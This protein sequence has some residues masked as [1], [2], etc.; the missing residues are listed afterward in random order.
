MNYKIAQLAISPDQK[1][2]TISKIIISQPS[3]EQ[4]NLL[5]R[6]FIMLEFKSR[7]TELIRL[8]NF[9]VEQIKTNYYRNEQI[10][11]LEKTAS[12]KVEHIFESAISKLNQNIIE[13]L[14]AEKIKFSPANLNITIGIICHSQLH[15]ATLGHNKAL[16]IYQPKGSK[17]AS[18]AE[19]PSDK[20][21]DLINITKKTADPTQE[22][23]NLNKLFSNIINGSIPVGGYFVFTNEA[24]YE[25]LSEKQ[26]VDIITTLPPASAVEQIKNVLQ[27]TNVYVP[28]LGLI[29]KNGRETSTSI[30]PKPTIR[31]QQ[32]AG[33]PV[34]PIPAPTPNFLPADTGLGSFE[35][36]NETEEKTAQIL[37]PTGLLNFKKIKSIINRLDLNKW[38]KAQS[39]NTLTFKNQLA[40][41]HKLSF[42]RLF[43]IAK[44]TGQVLLG[45]S[46]GLMKTITDKDKIG[47][48]K[49]NLVAKK[50]RLSKKH[51]IMLGVLAVVILGLVG[52]LIYS[53]IKNKRLAAEQA[54]ADQVELIRQKQSQIETFLI[55]DNLTEARDNLV[56]IDQLLQELPQDTPTRQ[57]TYQELKN[58]FNEKND[59]INH[60]TRLEPRIVADLSP[61]QPD[62]LVLVSNKLYLADNSNKKIY[63]LDPTDGQNAP[64]LD[65]AL[66]KNLSW[67]ALDDNNN[68]YY[69]SS[70]NS[71]VA[72]DPSSQRITNLSSNELSDNISTLTVYGNRV[73]IFATKDKQIY[74]YNRYDDTLANQRGWL[75]SDELSNIQSMSI[76]GYIYL[77]ADKTIYK[78]GGGHKQ[79]F[80]LENIY[81][82][83]TDPQKIIAL[84]NYEIFYVLEPANNRLVVFNKSGRFLAQY[85]SDDFQDL[86][87]FTVDEV[88][89]KAYVL[90]QNK[91]YELPLWSNQ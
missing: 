27:Q 21:Y 49:N 22:I 74:R 73:Y 51:L 62:N 25:Y 34:N 81:P 31:A 45:G 85:T 12:V 37:N 60:V 90:G 77:I 18:D 79:V 88:G 26:L 87:D 47:Q 13:F 65:N 16:L 91:V 15:F 57:Q 70:S 67:P 39:R 89:Q 84:Q 14:Q 8:A 50:K 82:E 68:I 7:Q 33:R 66:V 58:N 76:E 63:S 30:M 80:I 28:F 56:A 11:L 1:T 43:N 19:L 38:K 6:L 72:F 83:F 9:L 52:N 46:V 10:I 54:Y 17:V 32:T 23:F 59:R 42:N 41:K 4:E 71:V 78:Y 35:A 61:A 20:K 55:Y 86:K 48:L 5:G 44:T 3:A 29:I 75:D 64:I 69:L 24:L 53:G 40:I 36:L 2:D